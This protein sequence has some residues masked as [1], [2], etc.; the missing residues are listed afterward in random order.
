[1]IEQ[2]NKIYHSDFLDNCLHE[3]CANLII[4]DPPYFEVKGEFDFIWKSFDDYL[5]DVEKWAKECKRILSSNGTLI[6]WGHAKRI[7]YTQIIFDR[8]FYLENNAVWE[9][10]DCQTRRGVEEYNCFYPITE[11]FL[12]YSNGDDYHDTVRLAIKEVQDYLGTITSQDEISALLLENEIC[13]NVNSA[14]QNAINILSPKSAKCQMITEAQYNLIKKEKVPYLDLVSM[15][16]KKRDH[17]DKLRRPFDNYLKHSDV[18]KYSQ[19]AT[20]TGKY[21]HETIKPPKL[22]RALIL[23]CS[24]PNDLVVAPFAGSGT[25]CAMAIKEGRRAVGFDIDLKNVEMSNK[26]VKKIM[27]MPDLFAAI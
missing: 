17:Y 6:V 16:K 15:Y 26:R 1:M 11:R 27:M 12:I 19:E 14:K 2:V 10:T 4:A 24:R 9:K 22:T 5:V 25:E 8:F 21:E 13:K 7:A 18:F 23:T 3:K 20:I